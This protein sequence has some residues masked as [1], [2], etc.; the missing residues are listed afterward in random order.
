[1][2]RCLIIKNCLFT[3]LGTL[4][5][6]DRKVICVLINRRHDE[7]VDRETTKGFAF[8]TTE[9]RAHE[10]SAGSRS[11]KCIGDDDVAE[12]KLAPTSLLDFK[13]DGTPL[14]DYGAMTNSRS[15]SL[16]LEKTNLNFE[17]MEA[18]RLGIGLNQDVSG[19][20]STSNLSPVDAE[21]ATP[22][23]A[24]VQTV[25]GTNQDAGV[26]NVIWLP[27]LF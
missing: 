9:V 17:I 4:P 2:H 6:E 25:G 23:E 24:E 10:F 20:S 5:A 7:A 14:I 26:S 22:V 11:I 21:P 13:L 12:L 3:H 15:E 27:D 19:T 1:M 18:Y 16:T 8:G